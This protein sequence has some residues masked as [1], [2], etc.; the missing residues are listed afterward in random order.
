VIVCDV[1]GKN[2]NVMFEL[3]IRLAFDKP[4]IIVKDNITDYSFD[5]SPIEHV[6]YPRDLRFASIVDFKEK[7]SKK[8]SDTHREATENKNYTTFLKHFGDFRLPKI[9]EREVTGQEF[10]LDEL[11]N[12]RNSIDRI[13]N[14]TPVHSNRAPPQFRSGRLNACMRGIPATQ[15]EEA[16]KIASAYPGVTDV[17]VEKRGPMHNHIHVS[18]APDI[19]LAPLSE[20][21]YARFQI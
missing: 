21:L 3:G 19:D 11:K 12:L 10:I 20:E 18:A 13:S 1:S 17:K 15:V 14:R 9:T 5:T 16:E 4:T 8:I 6:G 2:P 7:L